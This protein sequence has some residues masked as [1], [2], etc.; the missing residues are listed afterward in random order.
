MSQITPLDAIING[1][2]MTI[3]SLLQI[4]TD[5]FLLFRKFSTPVARSWSTLR[6]YDILRADPGSLK[7]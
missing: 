1:E 3:F 2:L 4:F 7:E 6:Y 5:L